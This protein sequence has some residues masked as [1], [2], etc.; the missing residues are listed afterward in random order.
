METIIDRVAA[1]AGRYEGPGESADSGS[2]TGVLEIRALL[3]GMGAEL[4]YTATAPDGNVLHSE[5]TLLGFD[6]FSGEATLY[7][8]GS[9]LNGVGQLRQT[10]ETTFNNGR[11]ENGFEVQIE[12]IIMGA[13]LTYVWSWARPGE[14]LT[15][16]ASATLTRSD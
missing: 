16:Q 13:Q 10:N 5:H 4:T 2:F 15:E 7:V 11:G 3:D 9:E 1:A 14:D 6:M 8:M 12:I